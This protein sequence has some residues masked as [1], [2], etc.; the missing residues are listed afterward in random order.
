MAHLLTTLAHAGCDID[1][2]T[3]S[4]I[5]P[6][7][8]STTFERNAD[9]EYPHGY[10]YARDGNPTRRQLEAS[11]ATIEGGTD[12]R[13]F[14]SGLAASAAI[15]QSLD[16]GD[17]ILIPDDVYHGFR[18]LVVDHFATRGIETTSV[19]MSDPACIETAFRPSTK[20]VWI[21]TPSNPLLQI[22]DIRKTAATARAHG[23]VTVVDNTWMTPV[24]Q[25]P[26]EL[27]ADLILHSLTK[28]I[29]GHSDALGGAVVSF[30]E[31]ELFDR[32]C[33]YQQQVGAVLD[34][35]SS[36]ITLRGLRTLGVR[37]THQS[38]TADAI[39]RFLEGHPRVRIVHYPGLKS[40]PGYDLA[41]SQ[42][43]G[44]GGMLSFEVESSEAD[45]MAVAASVRVFTRATSLGGTESLIEHRRSMEGPDSPTPPSLLR[46]SIG[47]EHSEDLIEDLDR[48]LAYR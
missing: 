14:S 39:A 28:Y 24:L 20:M 10:K 35:F 19:N 32:V 6:L 15:L 33:A 8:F 4:L 30:K 9:G 42:M 48:A 25:R 18:R 12:C 3:A 17:H 26:F 45:A 34:P 2:S 29:S 37:L 43:R 46:L 44:S 47:L 11:L 16:P 31:S 21:E 1:P 7:H 40:H 22:T 38:T 41:R 13:A 5:P 23:A 27:G 36:W